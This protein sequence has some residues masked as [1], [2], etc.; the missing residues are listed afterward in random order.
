MEFRRL[1]APFS[2]LPIVVDG[3]LFSV[4]VLGPLTS[5]EVRLDDAPRELAAEACLTTA[6][7]EAPSARFVIVLEVSRDERF[8]FG[9]SGD[10]DGKDV[11]PFGDPTFACSEL[12]RPL[13][14]DIC[15]VE[16]LFLTTALESML[17]DSCVVMMQF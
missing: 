1:A 5:V 3:F 14:V 4:G 10:N 7:A 12:V 11:K 9:E 13:L 6:L 17:Q 16:A 8:R 15:D 2:V